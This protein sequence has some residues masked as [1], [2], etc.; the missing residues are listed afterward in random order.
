MIKYACFDLAEKI[1]SK[2]LSLQNKQTMQ[3]IM[4]FFMPYF[5]P[6]CW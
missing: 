6:V 5:F 3:Y 4:S 1:D 2:F